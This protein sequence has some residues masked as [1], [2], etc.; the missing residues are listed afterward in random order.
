[1]ET[2]FEALMTKKSDDGL[3]DYITNVDKYVPEAIY[4]AI[5]ELKKRG[6]ELTD[7]ELQTIEAQLQKK[8]DS[9][10]KDSESSRSTAWDRNKVTDLTAPQLYSQR[11]I[12]GFSI[13]FTVI[14]GA[15]LLASNIGGKKERWTVIGFGVVYTGVAIFVLNLLPQ[16]T[17]LTLAFNGA[18]AYV[19]TSLFWNKYIGR[20]FRY[21][22]KPI[23]K[24]LIISLLVSVPFLLA[25]LYGGE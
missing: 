8:V 13:F 12:W 2:D 25:I 5:N 1:M 22:T 7:R 15:V 16:N 18:G 19:L 3:N 14:F 23:W 10:K 17:G 9:Q 21:Q 20:E 24:P 6:R 11:A 4:A